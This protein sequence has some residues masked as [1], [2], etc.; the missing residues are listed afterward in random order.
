MFVSSFLSMLFWT[1]WALPQTP[2]DSLFFLKRATE[3][4]LQGCDFPIP[5][6]ILSL[7]A[8]ADIL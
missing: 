6:S 3:S 1:R 4:W 8:A 7:Q 5:S 2:W